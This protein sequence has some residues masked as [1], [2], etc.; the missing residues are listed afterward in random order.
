MPLDDDARTLQADRPRGVDK[1]RC[2]GVHCDLRA[3]GPGQG[4][5]EVVQCR[6]RDGVRD[7]DPPGRLPAI[8]VMLIT[9]P[10]DWRND[11][12]DAA[13]TFQA[14]T[15]STSRIRRQISGVT[16]PRSSWATKSVVAAL[17]M[18]TSNLSHDSS[19]TLTIRCESARSATSH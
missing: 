17:L 8:E 1:A 6:L 13:V 16:A 3:K 11:L 2:D 18:T 10:S 15:T 5:G 9:A 4:F 14:P 12:A 19:A 7:A